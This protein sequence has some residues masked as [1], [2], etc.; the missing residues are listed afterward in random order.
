MKFVRT[1]ITLS[2]CAAGFLAQ[3]SFALDVDAGDYTA[4][5]AGTNLGLLYYQHASRD[6]LYADGHKVPGKNRLDSDVGIL[7]GV[8]YTDI[9]GY[10]VDPQFLLPFGNLKAK[11]S[12]SPLGEA[13]GVG[14]LILAATVWLVNNPKANTYFGITPFMFLPTGSYDKNKALNLGE[15]RWK[16]TLQAGF[17][18]GLTDKLLLDV[19]GDVTVF[20]HNNDFG[21]TGATLKQREQ[22]ELQ[23]F[24]RYQMTPAWDL[25][26]GVAHT[27]GGESEVNGVKQGD[28]TRT[29][30]FS[31]GSAYF[32]TPSVQLMA[33]YGRDAS[34]ENGFREENR[35]N[36][37]L[38]TV[39]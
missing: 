32:I 24:L 11:D 27:N 33:N 7:R 38:L 16:F 23:T 35:L 30:K 12:L 39:F 31:L 21:P 28:R 5:P 26:L 6:A 25:R 2:L 34:V 29:T 3:P 20:G 22:Y 8:H 9:G 36:L 14:D 15:N 10:I 17:I 37:R 19:I 18:T 13:N 4:L 1:L